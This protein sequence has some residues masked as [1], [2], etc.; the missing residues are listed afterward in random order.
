MSWME[1]LS[2]AYFVG[3]FFAITLPILVSVWLGNRQTQK[4]IRNTGEQ[5]QQIIRE[6]TAQTS[7]SSKTLMRK[8]SE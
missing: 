1:I 2:S 7:G 6:L 5:T 4:I 3:N 8:L